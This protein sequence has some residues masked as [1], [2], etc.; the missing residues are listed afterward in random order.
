MIVI[1]AIFNQEIMLLNGVCITTPVN[2]QL[3]TITNS[4]QKSTFVPDY[5]LLDGIKDSVYFK[6]N[7]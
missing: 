3:S 6:N 7:L 5:N 2:N 1:V 4:V